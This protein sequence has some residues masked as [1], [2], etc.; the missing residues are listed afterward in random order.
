MK[1]AQTPL[2]VRLPAEQARRLDEAASTSGKSKRQLVE[3][4]VREHLGD[5]GLTVGRITLPEPEPEILTAGEAAA[6]LRV[7]EGELLAA[8]RAGDLPGREIGEQWRFSRAALLAWLGR[9]AGMA[10]GR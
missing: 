10:A 8:A 5:D 4:A 1:P 6:L 3:D 7:D 9:E 2:Y